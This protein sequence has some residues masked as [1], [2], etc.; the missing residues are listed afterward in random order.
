V[1]TV[2]Q[3]SVLSLYD[4]T[5]DIHAQPYFYIAAKYPDTGNFAW[6]IL[7]FDEDLTELS[8]YDIEASAKGGLISF[9]V[10]LYA[11][12]AATD[13]ALLVVA[14]DTSWNI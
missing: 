9:R 12:G 14:Q 3:D 1:R 6:K 8:N 10:I 4:C 11:G 2:D 13:Q 5:S 7:P